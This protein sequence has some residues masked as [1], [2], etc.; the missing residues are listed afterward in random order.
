MGF[1]LKPKELYFFHTVRKKQTT[2]NP[3]QIIKPAWSAPSKPLNRLRLSENRNLS[4]LNTLPIVAKENCKEV[5][6]WPCRIW[7]STASEAS[8]M[9][10]LNKLTRKVID[11]LQ[12]D[13]GNI[14]AMKTD[15]H[16]L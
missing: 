14:V 2:E 8:A 7:Q 6:M 15:K 13:Q 16:K 4:V 5:E 1:C 9:R 3:L 10:F 11:W 12:S